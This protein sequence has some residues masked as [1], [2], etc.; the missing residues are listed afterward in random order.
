MSFPVSEL[1][2]D[3]RNIWRS[4]ELLL[5]MDAS[6]INHNLLDNKGGSQVTA[7]KTTLTRTL[8]SPERAADRSYMRV[9]VCE[10][11]WTYHN[12]RNPSPAAPAPACCCTHGSAAAA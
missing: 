6:F 9:G 2:V 4:S 11:A 8:A 10:A 12:D 5:K 3:H 7:A 1:Q